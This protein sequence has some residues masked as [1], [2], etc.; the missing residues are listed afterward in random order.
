[1]SPRKWQLLPYVANGDKVGLRCFILQDIR[2]MWPKMVH[3]KKRRTSRRNRRRTYLIKSHNYNLRF[4]NAQ[5]KVTPVLPLCPYIDKI[6]QEVAIQV[7]VYTFSS[8]DF[9]TSQGKTLKLQP[10]LFLMRCWVL[11]GIRIMTQQIFWKE[12]VCN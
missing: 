11:T 2:V 12:K 6:T 9:I 10:F 7:R 1:M 5:S 8:L 3:T 4:V